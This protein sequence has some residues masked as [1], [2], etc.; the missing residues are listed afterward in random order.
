M[1]NTMVK[2][3]KKEMPALK[4]N[5]SSYLKLEE[6]KISKESLL[7][8]GAFVTSA[9]ASAALLSKTVSAQ[10]TNAPTHDNN[11]DVKYQLDAAAGKHSHHGS[12]NN[13]H[14]SY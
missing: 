6:G 8:V 11:V 5:I 10:H 14:S 4:K 1:V 13:V 2:K 7:T 9:A 12:H 3:A